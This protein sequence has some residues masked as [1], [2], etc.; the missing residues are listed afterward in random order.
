MKE[1]ILQLSYVQNFLLRNYV[2]EIHIDQTIV[3]V[4]SHLNA[5]VSSFEDHKHLV[6]CLWFNSIVD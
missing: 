6:L 2:L 5:Q 3:M 1:V 4:L